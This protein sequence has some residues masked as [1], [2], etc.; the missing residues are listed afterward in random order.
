[1]QAE[2][3][4]TGTV[5]L[6]GLLALVAGVLA[7]ACGDREQAVEVSLR[8]GSRTPPPGERSK[9][10]LVGIGA[11]IS[12]AATLKTYGRLVRQIGKQLGKRGAT[13][14]RSSYAEI[15]DLLEER[16]IDCALVCTGAYV[17]GNRAFGMLP[18][19]VPVFRGSPTYHSFVIVRADSAIR[20]FEDLA[21][22]RF[23]FVD[24]LSNTGR[25]YPISRVL[26]LGR[27][28]ERFFL[29]TYTG[30]HDNSIRAVQTGIVAGAAVDGLI[31][32]HLKR[33]DPRAVAGLRILERSP[34]YGAPPVVV[35]PDLGPDARA[36][37]QKALLDL[38]RSAEG[39]AILADLGVDRFVAP[40]PGLYTSAKALEQRIRGLQAGRR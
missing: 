17:A 7:T 27:R 13:V 34:A 12:P 10:L 2:R 40:A 39:R 18:I 14:L 6:A 35:H 30:S 26:D 3:Y 25:F 22:K 20:R 37:L 24:P 9:M 21:G 5:R 15:N 33:D 11:M 8:S 1:M 19:A 4:R 36:A 38:D 29:S 31:F 28:P 32:D 23:A 16:R